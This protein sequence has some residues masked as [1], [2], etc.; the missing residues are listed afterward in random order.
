MARLHSFSATKRS[1]I[2]RNLD[3]N[4]LMDFFYQYC[5]ELDN[6]QKYTCEENV[7]IMGTWG[8]IRTELLRRLSNNPV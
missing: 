4:A 6:G 8:E 1:E 7:E 2:I 5:M 3:G